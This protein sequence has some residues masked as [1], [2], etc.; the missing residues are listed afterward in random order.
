[1]FLFTV[2][3]VF[4]K[5]MDDREQDLV[6]ENGSPSSGD[7]FDSGDSAGE[8]RAANPYKPY[9]HEEDKRT[10]DGREVAYVYD[11]TARREVA[12]N[13]YQGKH[14]DSKVLYTA[15]APAAAAG[16]P[17][18]VGG[19]GSSMEIRSLERHKNQWH[20]DPV[21]RSLLERYLNENKNDNISPY[22]P[23]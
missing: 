3:Q 2:T 19:D 10:R 18:I 16:K 12:L 20:V 6:K 4:D 11:I 13:Q 14:I 8:R 22:V 21:R 17:D 15:K 7:L 1:M 5:R 9:R 23:H